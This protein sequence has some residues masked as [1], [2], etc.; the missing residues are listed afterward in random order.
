MSDELESLIN[1][2]LMQ[3]LYSIRH[4][5]EKYE[6]YFPLHKCIKTSFLVSHLTGLETSSGFW[7]PKHRQKNDWEYKMHED[8][9]HTWNYDPSSELYIDLTQDQFSETSKKIVILPRNNQVLKE[10]SSE[11]KNNQYFLTDNDFSKW[12]ILARRQYHQE[13]TVNHF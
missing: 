6:P 3:E 11:N 9:S 8:Q 12:I 5:L 1:K 13:V 10:I 7:I 4:F 2:N